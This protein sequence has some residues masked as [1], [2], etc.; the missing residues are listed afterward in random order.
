MSNA[1]LWGNL[2]SVITKGKDS[3]CLS[4]P[5]SWLANFPVNE[6]DWFFFFLTFSHF[7]F[8]PQLLFMIL[9]LRVY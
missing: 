8:P 7:G 1:V 3:N 5:V 9:V 4:L 2:T 6:D